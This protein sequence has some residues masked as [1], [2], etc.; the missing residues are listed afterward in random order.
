MKLRGLGLA[1]AAVRDL[2][3][4]RAP[5]STEE[6]EAF[7]T[8]VL[9]G[10]VL[11]R[12]SAGLADGTI[13]GDV[14]NLEQV[15]TWFGRPLWD[16]E[17]A[18]AD[19]Y[20]G[21]VMRG[22]PSGTRLARSQAL[23]TYF[24]FLELRHK[25]EIHQLTGR[26]VDCPIDEMNRPRGSKDAQ[27]RIPPTSGEVGG[28][29]AGWAGELATCRKFGPTARNYTA[30]RL[31]AG[32]GLRVNEACRL[33]LADIK[34]DLGRFGK[35]HVRYG[36][37]S[38]GSGPRERMVPLINDVGRTLRWFIEDV[39]GQFD[40]DHT[41]PGAPLFPSERKNAD[42]S[43]R[44]VGDD[45]LRTGLK[46]AAKAHLPGWA[47][48]LTPHVLRHFCASELYLNGM[49]LIAIQEVLGHSWIATT[50]RYVHV[51]GTRVEDAWAAGQ[52]RAAQR[53]GGLVR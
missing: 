33:D 4:F 46:E 32:V 37:G 52:E 15:R 39:W 26:V 5:A 50:M 25:V 36:K 21:R 51:H 2:R 49:D 12:A 20:F 13:R 53:L 18:D 48:K 45:A 41:R 23:T 6:L 3:E 40:D 42:G 29:F 30:A 43:S 35:L 24:A 44:Q 8:D 47:E 16:M 38:R 10:F 7:E 31:M 17:P 22:S 9:A 11:A 27:L 34:W 14:G 28:L 19:A 1:L